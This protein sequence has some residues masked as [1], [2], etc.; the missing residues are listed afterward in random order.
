MTYR[1][2]GTGLALFFPNATSIERFHQCCDRILHPR[3]P[4][5]VAP[6]LEDMVILGIIAGP[7]LGGDFLTK[8]YARGSRDSTGSVE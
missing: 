5:N 6:S 4:T 2:E 3:E 1:T 8:A 7:R